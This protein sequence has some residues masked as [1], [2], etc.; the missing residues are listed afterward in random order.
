MKIK[1][2]ITLALS[3]VSL[4]NMAQVPSVK[5]GL[6]FQPKTSANRWFEVIQNQ[7]S[8][9]IEALYAHFECPKIGP[10]TRYD[11]LF[12]YSSEKNIVPSASIEIEAGDPSKCTGGVKAAIFSDGHVEGDAEALK[13]LYDRRQGAY[14]AL[15]DL[16]PLLTAIATEQDTTLH[17]MD[18][19][20]SRLEETRKTFTPKATGYAT[21]C[22]ILREV[23]VSGLRVPSDSTS[24]KAPEIEAL[25]NEKGISRDQARAI[26]L[27]RKFGE[28]RSALEGHLEMPLQVQ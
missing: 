11:A 4:D 8:S 13:A 19:L 6:A 23:W 10:L 22:V 1:M 24:H 20:N 5:E 17:V 2:L 3:I 26:I 14:A 12:N 15:G 16:I 9:S 18:K 27:T 25:M 28:W 7:G 21:V